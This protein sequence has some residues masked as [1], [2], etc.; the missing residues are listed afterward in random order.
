MLVTEVVAR[1]ICELV[2]DLLD[3][4]V[5]KLGLPLKVGTIASHAV[6]A[7][8][9]LKFGPA[10]APLEKNSVKDKIV[11]KCF[12]KTPASDAPQTQKEAPAKT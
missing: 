1:S 7:A 11:E 9:K 6:N 12:P 3:K 8:N 10:T 2:Y 5:S 4:N